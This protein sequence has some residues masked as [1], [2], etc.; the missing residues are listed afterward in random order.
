MGT[1]CPMQGTL[2]RK[3]SREA[4]LSRTFRLV[5]LSVKSIQFNRAM[6]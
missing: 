4:Y 2:D 1:V 6:V 5:L 3:N